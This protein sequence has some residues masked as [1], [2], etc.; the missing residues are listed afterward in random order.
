MNFEFLK[1]LFRKKRSIILHSHI[2]KNAGTTFDHAL[3]KN[4]LKDFIDHRDD[5]DLVEEKQN[6]L[7]NYLRQH[8]NTKAFSSHSI[9]FTALDDENFRFHQVYFLR[10]PIE[11]IKSVYTFEKQQPSEVSKGT[12]M[13]KELNMQEYIRWRMRDDV[14]GTIRN[15]HTIFLSGE[16]PSFDDIDKVYIQA[17]KNLYKLP[18]IGIVDRYDES[19]VVFEEYLKSY[20]PNV[21]LSYVRKNVTDTNKKLS[22]DEKANKLLLS[23]DDDL[24]K[25][26]LEKNAYDIELYRLANKLLDKKIEQIDNF[27][28]K[29]EKF[30]Q[31]CEVLNDI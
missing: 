30:K 7:T 9:H 10:H 4:F 15:C 12:K 27:E 24:Q 21:D 23:L 20:F 19:M 18:L 2:F 22:V 16:G 6:Y 28:A 17:K 31:K 3:E 14:E 1:K 13:A 8:E 5:A 25:L 29:L 11:R 26:V